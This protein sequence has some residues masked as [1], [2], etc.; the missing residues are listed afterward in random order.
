MPFRRL[1]PS[2]ATVCALLCAALS[3]ACTSH[4]A[5]TASPTTT[6]TQT[7]ATG[8]TSPSPTT[9]PTRTGPLTTGPNVRP[10]EHPP[11]APAG[12]RRHD[13]S[14]ALELAA[15]YFAALDWS[16]ATNDAVLLVP[17]ASAS[18]KP[19]AATIQ[20]LVSLSTSKRRIVGGRIRVNSLDL[21]SGHFSVSSDVV[22]KVEATQGFEKLLG[23][24]GNLVHT[25]P[26]SSESSLVF[27]SW[28]NGS[29]KVVDLGGES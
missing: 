7:A 9:S 22:V 2:F 28:Q 11:S 1:A 19:C 12:L 8:T 20:N 17:L 13:P 6:P 27:A 24:G 16:I 5:H 23:P 25:V 3:S 4:T 10:G 15:Y 26:P 29:W 14:G 18:C 21:V